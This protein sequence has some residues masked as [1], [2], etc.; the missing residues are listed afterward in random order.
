MLNRNVLILNQNY[1]PLTITKARRAIVLVFLGKA[2][3]VE[4][5]DGIQIHSVTRG[6]PL[7]SIVRL[8][9]FIKTPRSMIALSRKNIIKR[10]HHQCQYCGRMDGPMTTDHIVP[11]TRGGNDSWENLVCACA[12]CNKKKGN[13]TLRE[14]EMIL[15]KRPRKPHF[16][17][18]IHSFVEI[19]DT[20]WR[21][22]LFMDS[23]GF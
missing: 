3:V 4:R 6:L 12:S 21:Q 9:F 16:F 20:R 1:E 15:V 19:P 11:K 2:E 23:D 13:H 8:A 5:Y 7:P 18:F 14:S 22:Y 10:D 17:S